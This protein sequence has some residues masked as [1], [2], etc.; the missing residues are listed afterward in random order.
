MIYWFDDSGK[1][2]KA[3]EE[4][5]L[6]QSTAGFEY[7]ESGCVSSGEFEPETFDGD[8]IINEEIKSKIYML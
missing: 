1:G 4:Q 6:H 7:N 5:R 2:S 8:E 3:Y